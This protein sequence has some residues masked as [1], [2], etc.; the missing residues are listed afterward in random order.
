MSEGGRRVEQVQGRSWNPGA[1]T[2]PSLTGSAQW[3]MCGSMCPVCARVCVCVCACLCVSAFSGGWGDR[4][5]LSR[6]L[7]LDGLHQWKANM[8]NGG[9]A[10]SC[11]LDSPSIPWSSPLFVSVLRTSLRAP[12]PNRSPGSGCFQR[13]RFPEAPAAGEE[14][15]V[16]SAASLSLR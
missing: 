14:P 10:I 12:R 3:S 16:R 15:P 7:T 9:R 6:V 2:G 4:I 8:L 11:L 5:T 13:Q 1:P